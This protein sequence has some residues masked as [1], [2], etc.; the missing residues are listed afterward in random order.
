M[1]DA[2]VAWWAGMTGGAVDMA[3]AFLSSGWIPWLVLAIV[4]VL[5]IG[6]IDN[7]VRRYR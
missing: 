4:A 6:A 3:N 2:F 1:I 7:H 5:L